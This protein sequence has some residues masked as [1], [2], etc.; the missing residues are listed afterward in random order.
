MSATDRYTLEAVVANRNSERVVQRAVLHAQGLGRE[1]ATGGDVL[2][3]LFD[4]KK[5]LALWLLGEQ[6]MTQEDAVNFY[7]SSWSRVGD[8]WGSKP[9]IR[10][11]PG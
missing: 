6:E 8:F 9:E 7:S 4:E 11:V 1:I 10:N 5:S 2:V 3:A